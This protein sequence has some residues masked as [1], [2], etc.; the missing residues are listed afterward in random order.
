LY[1]SSLSQIFRRPTAVVLPG[2]FFRGG[3]QS[4]TAAAAHGSAGFMA[5]A[6]ETMVGCGLAPLA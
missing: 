3:E 2:R 6:G 1:T 5:H 4:G